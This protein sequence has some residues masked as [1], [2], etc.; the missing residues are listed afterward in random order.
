[1]RARV[2]QLGAVVW[3]QVKSQ[4]ALCGGSTPDA[5][6]CGEAK[7]REREKPGD[8]LDRQDTEWPR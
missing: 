3:S 5:V 4:P 1:M 8:L 6:V 7:G 2:C